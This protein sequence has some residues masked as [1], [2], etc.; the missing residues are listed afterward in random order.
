MRTKNRYFIYLILTFL[1]FSCA[2]KTSTAPS[3]NDEITA[4]TFETQV[5]ESEQIQEGEVYGPEIPVDGATAPDSIEPENA[6]PIEIHQD[7]KL[8][9]VLGPGMAKGIAHAA[10][11][12]ILVKN[13]IPIHCVIGTEMGAL[14]GALYAFSNGSINNLQ[15]QLF[16]IKN[17]NY[18]N[19]PLITLKSPVSSL[20]NINDFLKSAFKSNDISKFPVRFAT[21][22]SES[23]GAQ[24]RVLEGDSMQVLSASLSIPGIFD[25]V[26]AFGKTFV[27]GAIVNPLPI[28][29]ARE[30]GATFVIAVDVLAL[31]KNSNSGKKIET[32]VNSAFL[33]VDRLEALQGKSANVLIKVDTSN[34]HFTDF[35]KQGELLS[36]GRNATQKKIEEIKNLWNAH[37]GNN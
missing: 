13:E 1:L 3:A 14:V 20:S 7:P 30:M 18:F 33:S 29:L 5:I 22:L 23:T 11:L 27:S 37:I 2:G 26:N 12:E 25:S 17:E 8:C 9:V 6:Q 31:N 21:V 24:K 10:A 35:E 32:R 15:W 34:L 16:K 4:P 19:F 28:D 36:A